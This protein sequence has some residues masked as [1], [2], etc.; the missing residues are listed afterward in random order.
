[1]P[2][3][4]EGVHSWKTLHTR[5]FYEKLLNA[6]R[7]EPGNATHAG[8]K[9]G[10]DRRA[11]LFAWEKG[12]KHHPWARPIKD[13]LMEER[14]EAR[15][16]A[17]RKQE[18]MQL[19]AEATRDLARKEAVDARKQELDILRVARS[20]V[21]AAL[22]IAAE[23][24][25]AMRILA[26]V[27][28]EFCRPGPQGQLPTIGPKDAMQLMTRHASLVQKA[29]GAAE[30]VIQL[31]R[32][33]RGESTVNVGLAQEQ[34][35]LTQEALFEELEAVEEILQAARQRRLVLPGGVNAANST[36]AAE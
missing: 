16:L 21:L 5:D 24:V 3:Y 2:W 35:P 20:D 11:A 18:E 8:R 10:C 7:E 17:R 14:E 28:A 25:P 4:T 1:M 27:I 22:A 19:A 34:E 13:V 12:W 30:A 9:C 26:K 32:L 29:V 33:E 6:Y 36:A 31:S 15:A 23:C